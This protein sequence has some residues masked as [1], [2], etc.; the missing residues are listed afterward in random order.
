MKIYYYRDVESTQKI[1][2]K[3]IE[4]NAE[5][6][7]VVVAD[8]QKEGRGRLDRK[9]ISPVGGLYFS[10][11]L[12]MDARLPL[13]SSIAVTKTLKKI[14]LDAKIKWPNDI[15]IKNRK[16]A[17]ILIECINDYAILGIG[18]N[19]D[20]TPLAMATSIRDEGSEI[21]KETLLNQILKNLHLYKSETE[22]N[23]LE[24]YKNLCI[25][26]FC[27]YYEKQ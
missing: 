16:V 13:I 17:G 10:I 3:L 24:A 9:W 25:P 14:G 26:L 20:K 8:M 6:E 5:E 18:I 4:D 23:V 21:S 7:T 27:N 15:L 2:K 1:A 22:K 11:I 12:K 19:V